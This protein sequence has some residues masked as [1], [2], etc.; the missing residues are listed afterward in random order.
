MDTHCIEPRHAVP[1]RAGRFSVVF[2]ALALALAACSPHRALYPRIDQLSSEGQYV[3]A[4]SLVEHN[5]DEYGARNSVLYNL[6]RGV[7]YTYAGDYKKSNEA[8]AAAE[9]RMDDLYTQSISRNVAAFAVNDNTLPYRGED[10]EQ[11]IVNVYRAI[12]Y[13][14]LG[15]IDD[16]LVEARKVNLKLERIND[17]YPEGKKNVY[18]ED[19]FARM[20]AGVLYEMGGTF[21][22]INDAYISDKLAANAYAKDFAPDYGVT[23]PTLLQRNLL[24]TA[25]AMGHEEL[26]AAEKRFPGTPLIPLQR[27]AKEGQL[28]F[29][30]FAG[31]SPVK[32]EDD[33][34]A[35]MPDGH[36]LK[37]AFPRYKRVYYLINGSRVLADGQPAI[38]LQEAQPIGSIAIENLANRRGR[39]AA[40]AIAR[41]T[42]KYMASR[43]LQE[44]A[45]RQGGPGAELLA[46]VAGTVYTEASEQ[47]DLR[48]WQTLPDRVLIGRVLLPPGRHHLQVQYTTGGGSVVAT[49]DLGQVNVAAGE[50]R[51]FI[52]HTVR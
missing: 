39:I 49:R 2:A 8:F 31:R 19:A 23:A 35:V 9:H 43:E 5:K 16:A 6:D 30:H 10:F 36:L 20:L 33:I 42:A 28:Y 44:R 21:D 38:T 24:T 52:L 34:R 11:V 50:T 15:R 45:R 17:Q 25:Q 32:V 3:Q 1:A 14:Q 47:A 13:V 29:I 18:K 4:A 12:N 41:A 37:I 48:S 27:L 26:N 51:F 40:K 7:L 22:D 46:F